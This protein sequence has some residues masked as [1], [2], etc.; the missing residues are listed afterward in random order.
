MNYE[1]FELTD[2]VHMQVIDF[3]KKEIERD[4]IKPG[5]R[6]PSERVLVE[7]LEISRTSVKEAFAALSLSGII[8]IRQKSGAILLEDKKKD[9]ILKLT[10]IIDRSS[11]DVI[12]IMELRQTIECEAS[13]FASIRRTEKDIEKLKK[14]LEELKKAMDLGN[15]AAEEDVNFHLTIAHAT[16]NSL[17]VDVMRL[18]SLRMFD[19]IAST[20][21]RTL[22]EPGKS[23]E[24]FKEHERIYLAI[25]NKESQSA[26]QLMNEH[27]NNVKKRYL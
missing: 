10:S 4:N 16:R 15:L 17:F 12:E 5:E 3:L 1:S 23:E 9:I 6:L 18:L 20:R 8:K 26:K 21:K 22:Q 19:T 25:K 27:L 7:K 14:A 24:V 2:R 13:F 11:L